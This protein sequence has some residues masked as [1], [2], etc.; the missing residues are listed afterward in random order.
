MSRY[1]FYSIHGLYFWSIL[2]IRIFPPN[3]FLLHITWWLRK[4]GTKEG[5]WRPCK[6][7]FEAP[8][9]HRRCWMLCSESMSLNRDP[10]RL[11]LFHCFSTCTF[12]SVLS[13]AVDM[14]VLWEQLRRMLWFVFDDCGWL[15][16]EQTYCTPYIHINGYLFRTWLLV[17]LCM[18]CFLIV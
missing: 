9:V 11:F 12:C 5:L 1:I 10:S 8:E 14:S 3:F 4:A 2:V 17:L 15:L 18:F 13:T 6:F 16:L 7:H